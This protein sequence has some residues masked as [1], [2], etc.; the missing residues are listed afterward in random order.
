[1][2]PIFDVIS[3]KKNN[4]NPEKTRKQPVT[5]ILSEL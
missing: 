2:W 4:A 5:T 3:A 1:M